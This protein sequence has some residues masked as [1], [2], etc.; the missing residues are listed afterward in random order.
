[1]LAKCIVPYECGQLDAC[2]GG[3]KFM[4]W[5]ARHMMAAMNTAL[6][7]VAKQRPVEV[8]VAIDGAQ[9]SKNWNLIAGVKQGDSAALC[10]R[11]KHLIYRNVKDTTIQ[12]SNHCFSYI[13]TMCHKTEISI[14][15]MQLWLKSL[16]GMGKEGA[17]GWGYYNP[18]EIVHNLDL[19]L[20]WKYKEYGSTAKVKKYFCHYCTF[21]VRGYCYSK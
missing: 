12:S 7:E 15:W 21:E 3:G 5:D 14:E 10:P 13:M 19:S 9:I 11:K 18:M 16:K 1:M 20:M 17:Q 4:Q 8:H 2:S 6:G